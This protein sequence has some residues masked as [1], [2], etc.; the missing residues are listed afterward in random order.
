MNGPI[1]CIFAK[2][3]KYIHMQYLWAIETLHCGS[4][5]HDFLKRKSGFLGGSSRYRLRGVP[6]LSVTI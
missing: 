5:T 4:E 1:D 6:K 3:I 2:Y